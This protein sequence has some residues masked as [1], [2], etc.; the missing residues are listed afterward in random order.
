MQLQKGE[1]HR[2]HIMGVPRAMSDIALMSCIQRASD[3]WKIRPI[4]PG[5]KCDSFGRKNVLALAVEPPPRST[6][7]LKVNRENFMVLLKLEVRTKQQEAKTWETVGANKAVFCNNGDEP[8]GVRDVSTP[9]PRAKSVPAKHAPSAWGT[10]EEPRP[11]TGTHG[12]AGRARH[13]WADENAMDESTHVYSAADKAF[14]KEIN[15]QRDVELIPQLAAANN[16]VVRDSDEEELAEGFYDALNS[17][18]V[19]V[20]RPTLPTI[21]TASAMAE[22]FAQMD[23]DRIAFEAQMLKRQQESDDALATQRQ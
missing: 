20:S 2:V 23:N 12:I 8:A 5:P 21:V 10:A 22:R 6:L 9:Q 11:T 18:S 13:S 17:E 7:I 16:T 4:G 1:G 19:P 14:V 15:A 3:G